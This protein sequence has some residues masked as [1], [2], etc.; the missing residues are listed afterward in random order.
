MHKHGVAVFGQACV[1]ARHLPR[2]A[3]RDRRCGSE[4]RMGNDYKKVS[5]RPTKTQEH[6]GT[7]NHSHTTTLAPIL[8]L[9][10][11]ST[12][13]HTTFSIGLEPQS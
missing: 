10:A 2:N 8:T 3:C 9:P 11:A 5:H 6:K 12:T 4:K 1:T 7:W 13:L